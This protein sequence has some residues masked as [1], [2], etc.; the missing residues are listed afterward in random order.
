M[1]GAGLVGLSQAHLE[2]S[3]HTRQMVIIAP[4]SSQKTV[5]R[6]AH[7]VLELFDMYI[8]HVVRAN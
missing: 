1:R 3:V 7:L 5:Y 2:G 8:I 6:V 4:H